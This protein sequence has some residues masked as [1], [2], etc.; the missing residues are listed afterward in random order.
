MK[1]HSL[2][3][4]ILLNLSVL[5]SPSRPHDASSSNRFKL[6]ASGGSC[7]PVVSF[8][9]CAVELEFAAYIPAPV[10]R[11]RGMAQEASSAR[12]PAVSVFIAD[13]EA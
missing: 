11:I 12:K 6:I 13:I 3:K 9:V 10:P 5:A 1:A 2:G 8:A 4:S 7:S